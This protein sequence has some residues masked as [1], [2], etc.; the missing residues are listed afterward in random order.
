MSEKLF[1]HIGPHKTGTTYIQHTLSENR[2]LLKSK[3]L[4]Y[5]TISNINNHYELAHHTLFSWIKERKSSEINSFVAHLRNNS[6]LSS[7]EFSHLN[8]KDLEYFLDH[9]PHTEIVILFFKRQFGPLLVSRWQE[10]V[11]HGGT[12]SWSIFFLSHLLDKTQRKTLNGVQVL[13]DW[14][15]M[16]GKP[17][18]RIHDY[19]QCI[20]EGL[21]IADEL[22]K[23]VMGPDA[24]TIGTGK[25]INTSLDSAH[26]EL[27][28]WVN[29]HFQAK[30]IRPGPTHRQAFMNLFKKYKPEMEQALKIIRSDMVTITLSGSDPINAL[31][32]EF[33]AF[34]GF[35]S[36]YQDLVTEKKYQLPGE[37]NIH[38]L[39]LIN[40]VQKIAEKVRANM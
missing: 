23:S 28:R 8:R 11:K 39:S 13:T 15:K 10:Y 40:H 2:N 19:E 14:S 36:G 34:T 9:I 25:S 22:L 7:E 4:N 29:L 20:T 1:I 5:P 30:G 27:L 26:V 16:V 18:I 37:Q 32:E 6:L 21:D 24:P 12:Y 3:G 38:S 35:R 33:S 31:E 17:N